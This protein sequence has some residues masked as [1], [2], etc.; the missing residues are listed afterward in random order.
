[1]KNSSLDYPNINVGVE[2]EVEGVSPDE[3]PSVRGWTIHEDGSL[4]GAASELV[5]NGPASGKTAE[6]RIKSGLTT[7]VSSGARSSYRTAIHVHVD[8]VTSKLG[9]KGIVRAIA[10]YALVERALFHWED[11]NRECSNFC[12][13]LFKASDVLQSFA[14]IV[15]ESDKDNFLYNI[16]SLESSR[17]S[18]LNLHA[19]HKFGTIEFRHMLTTFDYDKVIQWINLCTSILVAANNSRILMPKFLNWVVEASPEDVAASVFGEKYLEYFDLDVITS[20]VE[21]GRPI[22]TSFITDTGLI[23]IPEFVDTTE[24]KGEFF[25]SSLASF[26]NELAIKLRE[27][28]NAQ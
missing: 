12:V 15:K 13:P 5:F 23:E 25:N 28:Y 17:Y 11:N 27:K 3:V 21:I 7:L 1:M 24:G 14:D 19:L 4:R 2:I 8:T 9:L 22:A 18:A 20:S 26:N 10:L 16:R 6:Q